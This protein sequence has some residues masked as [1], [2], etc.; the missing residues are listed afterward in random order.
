LASTREVPTV[1]T[2]FPS[3][4]PARASANQAEEPNS[5]MNH[6]SSDVAEEG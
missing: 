3:A 2:F 1:S 5:R 4:L 6:K